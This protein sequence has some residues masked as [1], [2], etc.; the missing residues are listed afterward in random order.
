MWHMT[1]I[2]ITGVTGHIGNNVASLLL[3][4]DFDIKALVRNESTTT[5][6]DGRI[7][8]IKGSISNKNDLDKLCEGRD[9]LIHLA[10]KV[11]IYKKDRE[12]IFKTNI[13]GVQ[14]VIDACLKNGL[15]KIIHFSSIHAHQSQG[16][17][18]QIDEKT[19]YVSHDR[20]AYDYS[21]AQGEQLM[22]K[23]RENGI[24]V[25]IINP[26]AVIGP[27]DF[28]PSLS[29]KML[30]DIYNNKLPMLVKG[31][32]NWV[33]VRDIS[34]AV[35]NIIKKDIKNEKFILGGHW[36]DL[37]TLANHVCSGKGTKH[38]GISLPIWMAKLGLPFISAYSIL[39]NTIPLYTYASLKTIE[40]GSKYVS[41]EN[42]SRLLN[43]SPRPL[44]QSVS[45]SVK[46]LIKH[47]S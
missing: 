21:K 42:A 11:S 29:A 34:A 12:T 26:T 5:P 8:I 16:I 14:N 1:K 38:K 20:M 45:E 40:E 32:F 30:M 10:A 19:A 22:L 28:I 17:S 9:I 39:S 43:Y 37:K 47:Y 35:L 46:W 2:A 15:K 18:H 6:L 13:E 24:D 23:A 44:N 3:Q 33:D 4:S 25:S 36:A 31:G 27:H 7:E 41:H